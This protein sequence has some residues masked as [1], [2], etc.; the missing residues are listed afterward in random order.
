MMNV[1]IKYYQTII[2]GQGNYYEFG[3]SKVKRFLYFNGL[4]SILNIRKDQ[5]YQIKYLFH[6]YCNTIVNNSITIIIGIISFYYPPNRNFER[7]V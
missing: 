5:K 1:T 3:T 6:F 4:F 7:P 2:Y